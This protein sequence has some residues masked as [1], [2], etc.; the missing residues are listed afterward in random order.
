MTAMQTFSQQLRAGCDADWRAATAHRFVTELA[1]DTISDANYAG[2]LILD[3]A[4]LDILVAHVGQAVT[5]APSMLEKRQYA[6][7]LGVLT[8]DEDDYFLRSFAAM[9]VSEDDWRQPFDHA[10]VRGFREIM[11]G[12]PKA[13]YASVLAALLPVEWVY[14]TWAKSVADHTPARFYL[15]EWIDLHIDPGFEAFVDWMCAEMDRIG[16]ALPE[17]ER[18][19]VQAIFNQ[20]VELEVAFF[21]AAYEA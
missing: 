17:G 21:D 15:K 20:A 2:Y 13:T 18:Q 16:P 5:T 9:G 7:F 12:G 6:G 8:G 4:F 19:R 10:V 1:N 11:L 3:Y 14:L